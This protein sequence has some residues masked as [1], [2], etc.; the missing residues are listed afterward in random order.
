MAYVY[1]HIRLDKNQPFYIGIS[2]ND[3]YGN[4]KRAKSCTGRNFIWKRIVDKTDYE[5]EVIMDGLTWEE[6]KQ[7]EIE[8]IKLYGRL[9]S[10]TGILSN[11]TDGG[12]GGLGVV[13][14]E[15]T[16]KKLS[17]NSKKKGISKETREK[18]ASKLRGR[19]LPDWQKELLRK[20]A[21]GKD[22]YWSKKKV[23]QYDLNGEFVQTFNSINDAARCLNLQQ[24]NI[25]KVLK[26]KRSH[27]G[28]YI[29]VYSGKPFSLGELTFRRKNVRKKVVNLATGEVYDTMSEA[30]KKNGIKYDFFKRMMKKKN[31][32]FEYL[33]VN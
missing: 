28:G 27:T 5:V 18:M 8:F 10:G 19:P 23:D 4:C 26:K 11:M 3:N 7:K 21:I 32:E 30:A 1:R 13:V 24:A 20:A 6:A 25:G 33:S 9:N 16:R 22:V 31:G 29:F 17:E 15:I 14:S 2:K 12:E